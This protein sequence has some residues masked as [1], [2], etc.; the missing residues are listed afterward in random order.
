[1]AFAI[2]IH[3]DAEKVRAI[4]TDETGS[5]VNKSSTEQEP[6]LIWQKVLTCVQE[7]LGERNKTGEHLAGVLPKKIAPEDITAVGISSTTGTVIP[8]DADGKVLSQIITGDSRA[9][10][11]A[12]LVNGKGEKLIRK[13]GYRADEL[14]SL[15][16]ILWLKNHSAELY[17][18]TRKFINVSDFIVGKLTGEF[19][20]TD[21]SNALH[22][23]YDIIDLKWAAFIR[24]LGI[25][26]E[27]LP[28]VVKPGEPVGSVLQSVAEEI[29]LSKRT[30]VIAGT[31][32]EITH[33]VSS[34]AASAGQWN[35]CLGK[36]LRI[37]GISSKFIKDKL[38]RI[39]SH[40]HPENLWVTTGKS[41]VGEESLR[42]RF[43]GEDLSPLNASLKASSLIVYPLNHEGEKFP[44]VNKDAQGFII[45]K[46]YDKYDL[47][48]GY[49]E[50]I[51]YI[52][53]WIF[54]LLGELGFEIAEEIFV[55][56]SRNEHQLQI[57]ANILEKVFLVPEEG[58][59]EIGT[60]VL[61]ASKTIFNN[62]E[63]ATKSMVRIEKRI[64]P[65]STD[66]YRSK[67][68]KFRQ[69]CRAI[70]YE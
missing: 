51:G 65:E 64:E 55:T 62:L 23:G 1:M 38:S 54:E 26:P 35:S 30:T 21:T 52:E 2:G 31:T 16:R 60:A 28:K 33:F 50:G 61:S 45:G 19:S 58:S 69:V 37:T 56:G 20:T 67:Y 29:G 40:L 13:L 8:I 63:E 14:T 39:Y 9:D 4:L 34:G 18:K 48:S 66:I 22:A 3:I 11:E 36:N 32:A 41:S 70:G 59:P 6:E 42:E 49:I 5:V 68:R 25:M 43:R 17:R 27:C 46:P 12:K 7:L 47:Y 15:V 24:E 44:F 57:R 10:S 53:K